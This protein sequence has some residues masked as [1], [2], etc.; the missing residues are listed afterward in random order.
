M[1]PRMI[2]SL[3]L[4]FKHRIAT[5]ELWPLTIATA[6]MDSLMLWRVRIY[7]S[8]VLLF[9]I[10]I[11]RLNSIGNYESV[12]GYQKGDYEE[13]ARIRQSLKLYKRIHADRPILPGFF[14]KKR[15]TL[16]LITNWSGFYHQIRIPDAEHIVHFPVFNTLSDNFV[17]N[18]CII[19][20]LSTERPE[21]LS[22]EHPEKEVSV[23]MQELKEEQP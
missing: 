22:F 7:I 17:L 23:R 21:I 6:L 4:I 9:T 12:I 20:M 13:P 16:T 5:L 1:Y 19:F 14:A 11:N 8:S 2:S 10:L 3:L 18:V 15:A